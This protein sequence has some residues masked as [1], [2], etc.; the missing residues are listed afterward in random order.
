MTHF[1]NCP[2]GKCVAHASVLAR[3]KG[4]GKRFDM[5]VVMRRKFVGDSERSPNRTGGPTSGFETRNHTDSRQLLKSLALFYGIACGFCVAPPAFS[6]WME[7]RLAFGLHVIV[8]GLSV[9]MAF[10][11]NA[12][13]RQSWLLF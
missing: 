5:L 13:G 12:S 2:S 8:V 6:C 11:F 3:S 9:I 4:R 1:A 7:Q 10:A